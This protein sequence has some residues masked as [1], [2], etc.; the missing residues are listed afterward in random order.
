MW[1]PYRCCSEFPHKLRCF[2]HLDR[3]RQAF[4]VACSRCLGRQSG[5]AGSCMAEKD[6]RRRNLFLEGFQGQLDQQAV[7]VVVEEVEVDEERLGSSP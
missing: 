3:T 2:G 6:Q 7:G 1:P 4:H 5:V